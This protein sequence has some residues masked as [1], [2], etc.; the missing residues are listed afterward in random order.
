MGR[1]ERQISRCR[2]EVSK[3]RRGQ[4]GEIATRIQ[5]S[6]DLYYCR[7]PSASHQL[8][9]LPRRIHAADLVSYNDKHNEAN[10]EN[11]NDGANDNNSWNCGAEGETSDESVN[12]LRL[13]QT[14][15]AFCMLML[16]RGVP[17]ILMGDEIGQTQ[18]GNNNLIVRITN[19]AGWIGLWSIT[20]RNCCDLYE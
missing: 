19:S 3:G 2:A 13:Q 12:R 7:G 9:H 14:K 17:M 6:P 11:N 5:G 1:V 4:V 16:S 18:H 8:H 10:G 20:A 15:N